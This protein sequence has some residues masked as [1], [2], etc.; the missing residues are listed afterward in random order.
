MIK[1]RTVLVAFFLFVCMSSTYAADRPNLIF[2]LSDDHRADVLG[3]AGH[4]IVKTPHIDT[5]A[6][7]GRRF[8]NAFVTTSDTMFDSF[9]SLGRSQKQPDGSTRHFTDIVGDKALEFVASSPTGKP[10]CLSVSFNAAHASDGDMKNHYP[11]PAAEAALYK[12][13]KIP[14]PRLDGGKFFDCQPKFLRESMNRDRFYWR[15]DQHGLDDRLVADERSR[16]IT[17]R[18]LH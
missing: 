9:V 5:L 6:S 10:F 2:F 4:P 18:E 13:I 11:Y 14:R 12:E 7:R 17:Y 1:H 8:T 15:C 16:L 3:C